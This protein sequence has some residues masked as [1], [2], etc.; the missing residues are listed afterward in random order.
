[1]P[2]PDPHPPRG[3]DPDASARRRSSKTLVEE[4]LTVLAG[5]TSRTRLDAAMRYALLAPGKRIRPLITL[6]VAERYGSSSPAALDAAC[7][8]ELIHTASLILDD[9]PSMDDAKLRRGRA[10]THVVFGESTAVLASIGLIGLAF[11]GAAAAERAV[12]DPRG[13]LTR[14][15]A[16]AMGTR[17]LAAGQHADLN[18]PPGPIEATQV[19]LTHGLKTGALF[20]AAAEAG[21]IVAGAGAAARAD[22]RAVGLDIGLMFQQLDDVI[23]ATASEDQAGK[24]VRRDGGIATVIKLAGV[25]AATSLAHTH[26]EQVL[27]RLGNMPRPDPLRA[28][29]VDLFGALL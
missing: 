14:I 15:L 10:A 19:R 9:L 23:D 2:A 22:M 26:R 24:D 29:L 20:A 12:S 13:D 5:V 6:A 7:A 18:P 4:R 27:D 8:V 17:G 3:H 25:Q 16:E 21:A 28:L 1:M 11:E